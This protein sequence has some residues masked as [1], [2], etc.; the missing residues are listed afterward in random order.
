MRIIGGKDYYDHGLAYG[1]DQSVVFLRTG[2]GLADNLP[3]VHMPCF[4][5]A[6]PAIITPDRP[7]LSN[8][9]ATPSQNN[10][11]AWDYEGYN[12]K[13][14][15]VRVVFCGHYYGGARVSWQRDPSQRGYGLAPGETA[16]V[17]WERETFWDQNSLGK[18]LAARGARISPRD[19]SLER[20]QL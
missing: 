9:W 16:R 7:R 17:A 15:S 8:F 14:E 6:A 13:V 18:F 3:G 2:S 10:A 1:V 12:Y 4:A 20:G 19:R 11:V 5:G